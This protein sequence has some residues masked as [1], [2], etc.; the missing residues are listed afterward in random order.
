MPR[1]QALTKQFEDKRITALTYMTQLRK[2]GAHVDS[3]DHMHNFFYAQNDT[4]HVI[5]L[6]LILNRVVHGDDSILSRSALESSDQHRPD[7]DSFHRFWISCNF[8]WS[9][10]FVIF[11]RFFALPS[12]S[13]KREGY[14]RHKYLS[15]KFGRAKNP[16]PKQ[17][18]GLG[19]TV[20]FP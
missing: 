18:V 16:T 11:I 13:P 12:F 1:A 9:D 6:V 4:M 15:R 2:T 7:S 17:R 20:Q 14:A 8:S 3:L 5:T 10:N 19:Q